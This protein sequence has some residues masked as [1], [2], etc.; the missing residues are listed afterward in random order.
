[1]TPSSAP[2]EDAAPASLGAADM[3]S[4]PP[5]LG[6]PSRRDSSRGWGTPGGG[7]ADGAAAHDDDEAAAAL[8]RE[9]ERNAELT[10]RVRALSEENEQQKEMLR[11]HQERW[12][13][14][15]DEYAKKKQVAA[16][17]GTAPPK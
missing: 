10:E 2:D 8:A 4:A 3:L 5:V 7:A 1:V 17:G 12:Q 14:V 9:R 6:A 11:R 15:R 16:T 13:R